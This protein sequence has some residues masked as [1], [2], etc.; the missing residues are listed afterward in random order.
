MARKPTRIWYP[1]R[2]T[3]SRVRKGARTLLSRRNDAAQLD[4]V[5]SRLQHYLRN[6]A[7]G[8]GGEPG[9]EQTKGIAVDA[10]RT[11][12]VTYRYPEWDFYA[13]A[14]TAS[15]TIV[16]AVPPSLESAEWA[17]SALHARVREVHQAKRQFERLRS[18][19][20]RLRRQVQGDEL[21]VEACVEAMIDLN[22]RRQGIHPFCITV[23]A[24]E[25][26]TY[27]TDIFGSAGYR[28]VSR[29]SQLSQALLVAV[30][31][32]IGGSG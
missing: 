27:L 18:H 7:D 30:Q 6:G 24:S 12:D 26:E 14:F 19:R 2:R 8:S 29:P 22:A 23:D 32:L 10:P 13:Q 1:A 28:V 25:G 9:S 31:R 5:R 20:V 11:G 21:D 15:G 17:T 4:D 16:R 3:L